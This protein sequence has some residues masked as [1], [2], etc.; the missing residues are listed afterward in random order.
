MVSRNIYGNIAAYIPKWIR[1]SVEETDDADQARAY[2]TPRRTTVLFLDFA[3][4]TEITDRFAKQAEFGAEQ[5]SE[6]LNDCYTTLTDVV[7]AF[8]G[9]IV[10]F[11][12]DGFLAAWDADD[13]ARATHVAAQCALALQHAMEVRAQSSDVQIRQRISMDVGTVYYCRLGG[14]D[15][16]WRYAV[17]GTPFENV[18]LAYRKAA[19]AEIA[20][21]EAA[22][23]ELADDCEVKRGDGIFKLHRLRANFEVATAPQARRV[24]SE[25]FQSLVPAVVID[26]LRM[27]SSKWL[28]EFRNVSVLCISFLGV[29]FEENLVEFLQPCILTVQQAASRLEGAIFAVWMDDKG[30]CALLVFGA[31]PLA[32]EEDPL[33]AVEAGLAIHEELKRVSIDASIG[34]GSGRLFCGD[35]GGRSRREYGVLGPAINTAARLMEIADGGILCDHAT[36]E[37]VRGRVS[38]ALLQ[39]QRVKGKPA[40]IQTYRPVGT[41]T[42]FRRDDRSG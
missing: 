6:L 30:I 12:G 34:I 39:S 16:V 32:H 21:C 29:A 20:L 1:A 41:L 27:G 5:L 38:F 4:F 26:R 3:G 15:G 24:E 9:D 35:Y 7:D 11:A 33:R 14:H 19:I 42:L 18:G 28:A 36:A 37:A 13:G 10:A 23:R 17:V 2:A 40:P 8:G 25:R 31:P 22:W